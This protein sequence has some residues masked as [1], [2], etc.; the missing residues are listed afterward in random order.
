MGSFPKTLDV[1]RKSDQKNTD[2]PVEK[3]TFRRVSA[4]NTE[5]DRR[6]GT[7]WAV[8]KYFW[9]FQVLILSFKFISIGPKRS[10]ESNI[11]KKAIFP[12]TLA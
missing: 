2:L 4:S 5:W 11:S 8:H 10:L 12:V 9:Y 7:L 3:K 1:E 6:R